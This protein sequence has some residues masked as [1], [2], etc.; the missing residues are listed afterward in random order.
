M[1]PERRGGIPQIL[2][3]V[4]KIYETAFLNIYNRPY[5]LNDMVKIIHLLK[6]RAYLNVGQLVASLITD[7]SLRQFFT[8]QPCCWAAT[9]YMSS[10]YALDRHLERKWAFPM[11]LG[12]GTMVMRWSNYL[13]NW[14]EKLILM[15]K[16]LKF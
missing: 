1:E 5:P 3:A 12:A 2:L 8:F 4:K 11:R 16:S 9:L 15:P 7:E 10:L 6:L 13:K 14:V